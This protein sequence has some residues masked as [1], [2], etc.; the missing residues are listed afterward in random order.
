MA[1]A[2]DPRLRA[3][4]LR[5]I[6]DLEREGGRTAE[7]KAALQEAEL[8]YR[9]VVSDPLSLANTIRLRALTEGSA[10]LWK[11][12]RLLYERAA[13][14]TSLDLSLALEECDSHLTR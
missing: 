12:A 7:A 4:C 10:G 3:H 13:R 11:E 1:A 6:G 2:D 8:L 14:E 9:S 5:H